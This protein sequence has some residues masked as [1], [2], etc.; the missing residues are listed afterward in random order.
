VHARPP[1]RRRRQPRLAAA[2]AARRPHGDAAPTSNSTAKPEVECTVADIAKLQRE[3]D[4][5]RHHLAYAKALASVS[6]PIDIDA[7]GEGNLADATQLFVATMIRHFGAQAL[8]TEYREKHPQANAKSNPNT[9][10]ELL[11]KV[12]HA[13]K[14]QAEWTKAHYA[15]AHGSQGRG[16]EGRGSQ[17]RGTQQPSPPHCTLC[18]AYSLQL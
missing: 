14:K 5:A 17:G 15:R 7:N 12:E 9:V 6:V 8:I 13:S 4:T 2:A 1:P 16:R 3:L 18:Y 10:K 11:H